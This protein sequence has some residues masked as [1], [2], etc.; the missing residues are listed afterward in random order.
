MARR[1][2][3]DVL[4]EN[5]CVVSALTKGGML[6]TTIVNYYMI[7]NT[8]KSYK[9][10]TPSDRKTWTSDSMRISEKTVSRAIKEMEK[11]VDV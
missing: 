6:P 5:W 1:K 7:Y 10:G 9:G 11:I 2:V 4:S 3:I 8:Y